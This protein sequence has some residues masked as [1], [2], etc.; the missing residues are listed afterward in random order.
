MFEKFNLFNI[1]LIKYI[2]VVWN[3]KY[4]RNL[5]HKMVL[6][7]KKGEAVLKPKEKKTKAGSKAM[8]FSRGRMIGSNA[9][10]SLITAYSLTKRRRVIGRP[11]KTWI[12]D[13]PLSSTVPLKYRE[14]TLISR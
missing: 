11:G 1:N 6:P 2:K 13:V 3:L 9:M 14:P 8:S 4:P 10:P 12:C 7:R 5:V